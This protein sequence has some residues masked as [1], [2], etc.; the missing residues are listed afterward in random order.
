MTGGASTFDETLVEVYSS[1]PR[2]DL[3]LTIE[4]GA[5]TYSA[6]CDVVGWSNGGSMG[7]G[8]SVTADVTF[9]NEDPTYPRD[10]IFIPA[11]TFNGTLTEGDVVIPEIW[12]SMLPIWQRVVIKPGAPSGT[13]VIKT[14]D[15][16]ETV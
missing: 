1:V 15:T 3:T 13:T 11:N 8:H 10:I 7:G 5:A 6:A 14:L 12:P 9:A 4:P 2:M 16:G